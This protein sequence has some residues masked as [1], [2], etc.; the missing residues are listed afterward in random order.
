MR[1]QSTEANDHIQRLSSLLKL[2]E[3][4]LADLENLKKE[5]KNSQSAIQELKNGL[6]TKEELILQLKTETE[7]L[8][9][10]A[11]I[12]ENQF[13]TLKQQNANA[14]FQSDELTN[15]LTEAQTKLSNAFLIE[16]SLKEELTKSKSDYDQLLS[17]HES[18]KVN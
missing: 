6:K 8:R 14:D 18:E 1:Q 11:Q 10:K 12:A 4:S 16:S 7:L 9:E 13:K 2:N 17:R 15:R 5:L 3:E